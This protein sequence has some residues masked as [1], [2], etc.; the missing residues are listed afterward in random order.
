VSCPA[1]F[2]SPP[3]E[4]DEEAELRGW[5]LTLLVYLEM[6]AKGLF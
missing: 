2:Y 3:G 6:R 4:T 5:R 1:L